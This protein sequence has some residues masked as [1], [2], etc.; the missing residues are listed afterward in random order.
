MSS[1]ETTNAGDV[2]DAGGT[3][4]G[5]G[6]PLFDA[7]ARALAAAQ[8]ADAT[9]ASTDTNPEDTT[10][11]STVGRASEPADTGDTG[12]EDWVDQGYGDPAKP[13][14]MMDPDTP[15][16][17][18][19]LG[20]F[21][22]IKDIEESNGRWPAIDVVAQ[23]TTWFTVLGIN[24]DEQ[25]GQARQRLRLARQ[26]GVAGQPA[27]TVYGVRISTHRDDPDLIVRT[28]LH[29]LARQL[30]PGT[31][32]ELVSHDRAVLAHLEHPHDPTAGS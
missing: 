12:E 18:A 4:T 26:N 3:D 30:G 23:L 31:S 2:T 29:V 21:R 6:T 16:G 10:A 5:A 13:T 7:T 9:S 14:P 22:Q 27:A 8:T 15:E 11:G 1:D 32:I 25:P 20:L 24:P 28:A 19:I 17:A